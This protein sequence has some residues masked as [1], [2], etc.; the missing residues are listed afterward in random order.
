MCLSMYSLLLHSRIKLAKLNGFL[1]FW[2]CIAQD[3]SGESF[4]ADNPEHMKWIYD[5]VLQLVSKHHKFVGK[6]LWY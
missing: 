6:M 4:D 5:Q 2:A 1:N 3:R